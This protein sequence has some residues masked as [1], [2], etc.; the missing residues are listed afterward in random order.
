MASRDQMTPP[1]IDLAQSH[2]QE[3]GAQEQSRS[4]RRSGRSKAPEI[5]FAD[6]TTLDQMFDAVLR[7]T[8]QHLF[9]RRLAAERGYD[10][11]GIHQYRVAL[12][13]LRSVL[14]LMESVAPSAR[15][16]AFRDDAKW[17]M[18]NMGRARDW[19]V[20]T[21]ETLPHVSQS[22]SPVEGFEALA[23][24]AED[25]R[26]GAHIRAKT[27][28]AARRT[29]KFQTALQVWVDQAGWR[30]DAT[31]ENRRLLARPAH[32]YIAATVRELHRKVL[33]RGRK[34]KN[35]SP[36]ERHKVRLALK[37]LRDIAGLWPSSP[38]KLKARRRYEKRLTRLQEQLGCY[39]DMLI[40]KKL[41]KA[42]LRRKLPAAGR[43]AMAALRN[44][45]A[46]VLRDGEA[47]LRSAWKKFSQTKFSPG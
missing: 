39:N 37:R 29:A 32:S 2:P 46:S 10:P 19:D 34:F 1:D 42:M 44:W 30:V 16:R 26:Q 13:R 11:E 36:E 17:L 4:R 41:V 20:F 9:Q 6:D 33:K 25:H 40:A 14:M 45:Q 15:L 28:I 27:T 5:M 18:S 21:T 22:G 43:P 3:T 8:L 35:L 38:E 7:T 31:P 24:A 47:K 12:R 23:R